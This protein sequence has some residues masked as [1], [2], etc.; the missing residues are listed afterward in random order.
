[1]T[2][3]DATQALFF[4]PDAESDLR[5][6]VEQSL[7]AAIDFLNPQRQNKIHSDLNLPDLEALFHEVELPS[8]GLGV[9]KALHQ[10]I[11]RVV[12]HSVHVS[13]PRFIG[14]MTGATPYFHFGLELLIGA[15]NQN[16]VKIETALSG[17]FVE[18]QLLAWIHR[19][20]YGKNSD[21][22]KARMHKPDMCFGNVTSR[23]S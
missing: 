4:Q 15:L 1:M 5:R 10:A 2:H 3:K 7:D 6:L 14:H 13:D 11:E 18:G 21:Y 22:Y 8:Q 19:L 16:V 23:I 9:E 17:S 12:R 20:V